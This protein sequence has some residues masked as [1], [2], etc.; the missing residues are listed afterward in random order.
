MK[1]KV[2]D[3][4]KLPKQ[5]SIYGYLGGSVVYRKAIKNNQDYM[6]INEI[7]FDDVFA[8]KYEY[9]YT[10]GN[11]MYNKDEDEIPSGDY[12]AEE[13]LELY[14]EQKTKINIPIELCNRDAILPVYAREGDAG[15]DIRSTE[16]IIINAGETRIVPTGLKMAIPDGYE[17]QIRPRSGLSLKSPLRI[18]NS[19]GTIDSG[20]RDEIGIIV[21]NTDPIYDFT[22]NKNDRIAQM[23]L[24]EVP[25]IK[26]EVVDSVIDIGRN[27][28]GGFGSTDIN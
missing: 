22:I 12:F 1:F 16:E 27:R 21:T 24:Q 5:K 7:V 9:F 26:W 13:D 8:P 28:G 15:M 6:Y 11:K 18:A 4:V 19:P 20:Y 14:E 23:V 25:K 2:G 10:V 17:I 3:K